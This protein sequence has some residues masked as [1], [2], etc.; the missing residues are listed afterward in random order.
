MDPT[1]LRRRSL[2]QSLMAV[3]AWR[4]SARVAAQTA[5]GESERPRLLALAATVLPQEIGA[6]GHRRAVDQFLGWVADYK[7]GA[8]RDHGYGITALRVT[9]PSP[10]GNYRA[11]LDA[12]DRDAGGSLAKASAAD[13]AR[14]VGAA[15]AAANVRDLPARPNGG[16]VAT[17]LMGHYFN[18][19][20]ANDLAYRRAIGRD[21]CRGLA[22]SDARPNPLTAERA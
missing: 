9:P 21:A 7:A 10:A 2:L 14:L 12:L 1:M 15:I 4:P 6:D 3:A 16:H 22:G 5:F 11:Q 13:R 20:A 8:E 19:P 17:D 18:S